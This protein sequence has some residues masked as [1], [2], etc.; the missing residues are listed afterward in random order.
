MG[1]LKLNKGTMTDSLG[2]D[3]SG[4]DLEVS[5]LSPSIVRVTIGAKGRW[6][7]PQ[8]EI[9]NNPSIGGALIT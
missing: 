3:I 9:F 1:S 2:A 8:E 4:L 6:T 7:V 5:N